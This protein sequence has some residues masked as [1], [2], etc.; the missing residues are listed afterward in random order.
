MSAVPTPAVRERGPAPRHAALRAAT[1]DA[2]ARVD[3]LFPQGLQDTAD[4]RV[5]LRGMHRFSGDLAAGFALAARRDGGGRTARLGADCA[6]AC[7]LLA[8]DLVALRAAPLPPRHAAP[9]LGDASSRLGWA[10]VFAG[11]AHGAR[12]LLRQ[13]RA[14]G[15]D[16]ARGARFLASHSA[17][18]GWAGLLERIERHDGDVAEAALHR[19]ARDAFAH[20]ENCFLRARA[21]GLHAAGPETTP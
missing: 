10:Y 7:V 18:E 12:M 11:S 20:A 5:Y 3:A 21:E 4:Y 1:R 14:L 13:A 8:A 19:G 16:G 6:A 2:H 15:H 17:G 9:A